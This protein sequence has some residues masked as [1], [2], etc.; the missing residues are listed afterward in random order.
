VRP[1]GFPRSARL[2]RRRDFSQ[3]RRGRRFEGRYF[4]AYVHKRREDGARLGLAVSTKVGQA[5]T[6]NRIRRLAREAFRR[7]R[8][9]LGPI[10]LL[11]VARLSAS[12]ATYEE[13][14]RDVLG[15]CGR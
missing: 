8:A 3:A 12:G 5:V 6:R 14:A 15:A 7:V 13:V 11:L 1:Q 9:D 2:S 10:D 4:V